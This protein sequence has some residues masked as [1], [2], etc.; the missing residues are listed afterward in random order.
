M[1]PQRRLIRLADGRDLDTLVGGAD[2]DQALLMIN[3]TPT[4]VAAMTSEIALAERHGLRLL[5]YARPGYAAS[6]RVPGRT[7]ADVA[8][9]VRELA[10]L[11]GITRIWTLGWSGGGAHALA[12]AA[13]LPDL[14]AG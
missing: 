7:V 1:D 14:V 12:C 8:H 10:G 9:D 3:G 5:T 13:L 6:T 2:S 4:G 11:L